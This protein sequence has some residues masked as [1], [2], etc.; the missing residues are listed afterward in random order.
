MECEDLGYIYEPNTNKARKCSCFT[1]K[2]IK[3]RLEFSG[4]NSDRHNI[5]LESYKPYDQLTKKTRDMARIYIDNFRNLNTW[6]AFIGQPGCGKTLLS[7]AIAME[8]INRENPVNVVYMSYLDSMR[9]LKASSMDNEN[10]NRLQQRYLNAE[11][12]IIDDLFK[13][14]IKN[15][16]LIRY[17]NRDAEL[18]EA[19]IRHLCPVINNRYLNKKNTIINSECTIEQIRYLDS[20]SG[21]RIYEMCAFG[22][23]VFEFTG[24]KY[25]QRIRR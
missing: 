14:K 8:L 3:R 5:T 19:D 16:K 2:Q 17:M 12:L 4:I 21:D 23:M 13:D 25:N 7:M 6:L 15:G 10:Y 11:L 22:E 1:R 9:E 24:S 18:S 20:S